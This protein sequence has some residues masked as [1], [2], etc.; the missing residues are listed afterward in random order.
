MNKLV[1]DALV[2]TAI[3]LI[4]GVCLGGVYE[5][6]KDPIAKAQESATQESYKAVFADAASFE[7]L[8][9]FDADAATKIAADAGYTDDD[10]TNCVVAKDDA[11]QAIGYVITITS[12]AG[13][14][15]DIT[16]SMGV[17]NDGTLNGYSI[18]DISETAGL[19]MKA[20][21]PDFK[22]Q[23]NGMKAQKLE[24]TKTD[25]TADNQ[26]QA[27]SGATYTSKAVTGATNAAIY[28]VENCVG[29]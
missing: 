18:T 15:G 1:K 6:T 16:F 17:T 25:A 27:I 24:V 29:K 21:E 14:G 13:Y 10:I 26:V 4:A 2:L 23:F 11:G 20:K 22:D 8:E 5:I 7:D 3:T 9:G 12:H 19:G 28:F